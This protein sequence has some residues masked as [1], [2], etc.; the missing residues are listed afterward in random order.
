MGSHSSQD[1]DG[2]GTCA[3]SDALLRLRLTSPLC[4]ALAAAAGDVTSALSSARLTSV[5]SAEAKPVP[6]ASEAA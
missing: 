5:F 6:S 1:E 3:L 4:G 2:A